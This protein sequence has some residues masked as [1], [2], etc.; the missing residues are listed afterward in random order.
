M[1]KI[2]HFKV[3]NYLVKSE[4]RYFPHLKI[5]H[6]KDNHRFKGFV[7]CN[8]FSFSWKLS[9]IGFDFAEFV[10]ALREIMNIYAILILSARMNYASNLTLSDDLKVFWMLEF[11]KNCS[12][13]MNCYP[14]FAEYTG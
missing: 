4:I 9:F 1:R 12:V 11:R 7:S 14:S 6:E 10:K 2:L 5:F 13:H 3:I 8:I